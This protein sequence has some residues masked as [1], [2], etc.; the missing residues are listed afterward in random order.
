VVRAVVAKARKARP[1]AESD[2]LT[3]RGSV[4]AGRQAARN[5]ID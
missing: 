3:A 5:A 4:S 1:E 2:K